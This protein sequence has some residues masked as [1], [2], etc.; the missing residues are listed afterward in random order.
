MSDRLESKGKTE[1]RQLLD[2]KFG[3]SNQDLHEWSKYLLC[4]MKT[5]PG[6]LNFSTVKLSTG[7]YYYATMHPN[8]GN[9]QRFH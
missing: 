1:Q 9:L 4:T 2:V 5:R 3:E 7:S 8:N 6:Q